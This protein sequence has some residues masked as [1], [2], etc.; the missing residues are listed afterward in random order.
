MAAKKRD[1]ECAPTD[2]TI[3]VNV[4]KRQ[5]ETRRGNGADDDSDG[6]GSCREHTEKKQADDKKDRKHISSYRRG[7]ARFALASA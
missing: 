4:S 1:R 5:A 6:S 3:L 2:Q 7:G